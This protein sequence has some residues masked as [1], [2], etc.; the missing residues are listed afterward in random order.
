MKMRAMKEPWNNQVAVALFGVINGKR[1]MASK[2]TLVDA[3]DISS[4][5]EPFINLDMTQAQV[6]IDD[7][8][9][10]GLRPSEGTGSAGSL[11]ATENHL[12]DLRKILFH[13]EG[14]GL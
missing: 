5:I 13:K 11:K 10:C 4:V 7:L 9:S 1:M 8:W 12:S 14:I 2:V 6:L 3:P